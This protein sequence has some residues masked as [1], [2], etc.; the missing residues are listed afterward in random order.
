MGAYCAR[1]RLPYDGSYS[2]F[3]V[4]GRYVIGST[5]EEG[6]CQKAKSA[7]SFRT[8]RWS[9]VWSKS[10]Q[11]GTWRGDGSGENSIPT[12]GQLPS[13]WWARSPTWLRPPGITLTW[14]SHGERSGSSYGLMLPEGS[15]TRTL[16]LPSRSNNRCSGDQARA[17]LLTAHQTNGFAAVAKSRVQKK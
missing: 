4:R 12:A 10:C 14:R 3:R 17:L 7:R 16:P 5:E 11:G 9:S 8:K 15:L 6:P 1:I 2:T 13:C